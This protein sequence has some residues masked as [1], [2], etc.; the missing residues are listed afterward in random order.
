MLRKNS[1]TGKRRTAAVLL[2]GLT[3]ALACGSNTAQT[4]GAPLSEEPSMPP[5]TAAQT[6]SPTPTSEPTPRPTPEPAESPTP[7]PTPVPEPTQITIGAVG[8]I[9][10]PSG[11]VSDTRQKDGTYEYYTLFA[12]FKDLFG[13]VDLMC[14]NLEAPLAGKEARYSTRD[15]PKPGSF[16]FNAP[17]SVLDALK[18]YG[19]D[20][21]TTG[22]N[23]CLDKGE[24]GLY[25]TIETIRAAGFYQTGT[26]LNAEDRQVPCIVDVNGI[27]VGFVTVVRTMNVDPKTLGIEDEKTLTMY[28]RLDANGQPQQNVLDD[29]KRVRENGAEFVILFAHWDYEKDGPAETDTR[30]LAKTFLE[31]GVDCIV[32]SH[33]H[34]VKDAEY[35]TVEREDGPYT[36]LVLYSLGNFTANNRFKL[37]VG[38]Y[39]QLTL[40]KNFATGKVTLCDAAVLPTL[41]IKRSVKSGP[42]FAVFPAYADPEKITGISEPLSKGEINSLKKARALALKELGSVEGVRILDETP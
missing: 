23:H 11:I 34:R 17:D 13:S 40:E 3:L 4:G 33:P 25:R 14:A 5:Q 32:G 22:N 15:D 7:S 19:V 8:D 2:L 36:G 1:R 26:F 21:L 10:I 16:R 38:L 20:M 24:A 28:N 29:I 9:M 39:A 41:T 27:R 12:P 18:A 6:A 35:I 30:A 42:R 31:A 37:M